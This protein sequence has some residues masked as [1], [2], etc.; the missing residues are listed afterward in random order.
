MPDDDW[1]TVNI[2]ST[3]GTAREVAA[4]RKRYEEQRE[5]LAQ[6]AADAPSD[7][8]AREYMR[9]MADVEASLARLDSLESSDTTI[10][11]RPVPPTAERPAPVER[12]QP[13]WSSSAT[14]GSDAV[15][16]FAPTE[17]ETHSVD[18]TR[19]FM[20]SVIGVVLLAA[21]GFYAWRSMSGSDKERPRIVEQ[22]DNDVPARET[23]VTVEPAASPAASPDASAG[24]LTIKPDSH[25][26]GTIRKGTRA[27]R[28]YD[29]TNGS[30]SDLV[31]KVSRSGCRCMYYEY[32]D[33]L[34][35]NGNSNLTVTVD[36]GKAK[37]GELRET[38]EIK[39]KTGDTSYG[40]IEVVAQ[41][42]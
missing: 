26:F 6:L 28:Q 27:T 9:V 31:L 42:E 25:D 33:K 12:P 40:S 21:F 24:P 10:Y 13:E 16:D 1:G 29:L 2:K 19:A 20:F 8:L 39:A 17:T 23:P 18:K 14:A 30:D 36:G 32:V 34:P 11:A 38:I 37:K 41:I 15:G 3:K 5:I 35:A 7:H 4:L 22:R